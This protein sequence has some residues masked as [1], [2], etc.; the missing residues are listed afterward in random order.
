MH[1]LSIDIIALRT[2]GAP[3]SSAERS[4][5]EATLTPPTPP[6]PP[7]LAT[8]TPVE[9]LFSPK[10][11][12]F[13][14]NLSVYNQPNYILKKTTMGKLIF[15]KSLACMA[16]AVAVPVMLYAQEKAPE[17]DATSEQKMDKLIARRSAIQ[18]RI[19]K[20]EAE[21][22]T[23]DSLLAVSAILLKEGEHEADDA[24]R[25]QLKL[26]D[27]VFKEEMPLIEKQIK[28]KD[29][30]EQKEGMSK[31]A[32]L[33]RTYNAEL[34]EI[35][36]RFA[37][38]QKKQKDSKVLEARGRDKKKL[39][40]K[41][42]KE[43]TAALKAVGRE[44][45]AFGEAGRIRAHEAQ[46][47]QRRKEEE[48]AA[49][50]KHKEEAEL[51]KQKEK[52]ATAA[53][54]EAE[55]AKQQQEREKQKGKEAEKREKEKAALQLKRE[56]EKEKTAVDREVKKQKETEKVEKPKKK[57]QDEAAKEKEADSQ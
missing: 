22:K 9:F 12:T 30:Q 27:R 54:R 51:K 35:R 17:G 52:E 57:K 2:T 45:E 32:E 25:E 16:L 56:K 21:E 38:A 53:K 13:D 5:P 46:E 4:N 3:Q 28:S 8:L 36:L 49:R 55:K 11:C 41:A 44:I 50:Q 23:A 24:V 6:T 7:P 42:L 14:P 29:A 37:A 47:A 19:S 1:V 15:K 31:K 20:A 26:E 43:A 10:V 33:R 39:A 34:K 40:D 48:A 18:A